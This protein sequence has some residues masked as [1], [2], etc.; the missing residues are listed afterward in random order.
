MVVSFCTRSWTRRLAPLFL[1]YWLLLGLAAC[2]QSSDNA[3]LLARVGSVEIAADDLLAFEATLKDKNGAREDRRDLLQILVDREVLL[4]ETRALGLDEDPETLR[5]LAQSETRAL[6]EAMLRRRLAEQAAVQQEEIEKAYSQAGWDVEMVV[7]EIFVPTAKQARL[8]LETLGQGTDF[9]EVGRQFAVEP[10]FGV[11]TG[12]PKQVIYALHDSPRSLVEAIA[13]LP[14][15]GIT[16]PIP[17]HGGFVVATLVERRN[18][19]LVEVEEG[20]RQALLKE[21]KKQLRQ[22]YLR[23]LKWDFGTNFHAEGMDLVVAALQAGKPPEAL[24]ESQRRVSVYSFE[25]FRMDVEEVMKAVRPGATPWTQATADRVNEKLAESHF[26]NKIMA[27]D[28]RRKGIDQTKAFLQWRQA[29]LEDLVLVNLRQGALEQMP[30][31]T[32]D[33]LEAFYQANKHRFKTAAWARLQEVLVKDP[34]QAR[35]L[36][37]RIGQGAAMGALV[38]SHSSRQKAKDEDGIFYISQSQAPF[39]GDAWMRAVMNAPLNQVQG[40]VETR[41]EYSVFT[42]LE[43]YPESYHSLE[44]DR[45][46]ESVTRDVLELKHREYFNSYLDGLKQ[47]YADRIEVFEGN[48]PHLEAATPIDRT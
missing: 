19:D 20:I 7:Q 27:Q 41:G 33:D 3:A 47:K 36:A 25:G 4:L 1:L 31:V 9:A 48:L 24:D 23:H 15:G 22:T 39:F 18:A 14:P 34:V 42:V 38:R 11:S 10:Y 44:V 43:R 45:V 13:A 12:G 40:P 35:E 30:E 16:Q 29:A 21:K 46:R 26:P 2:G 37:G 32:E 5:Q 6:A 17:L 8:V 28:A